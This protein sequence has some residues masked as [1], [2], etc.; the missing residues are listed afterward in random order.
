MWNN[1]ATLKK[2]CENCKWC[3][4]NARLHIYL[5][6]S[7][8]FLLI[9][10]CVRLFVL[11][12]FKT[13][14]AHDSR[15]CFSFRFPSRAHVFSWLVAWKFRVGLLNFSS[16]WFLVHFCCSFISIN[17]I[18]GMRCRQ[19]ASTAIRISHRARILIKNLAFI[20]HTWSFTRAEIWICPICIPIP[21]SS[22]IV[23]VDPFIYVFDAGDRQRAR[24]NEPRSKGSHFAI[25]DVTL[26]LNSGQTRNENVYCLHE[27]GHILNIWTNNEI[28]STDSTDWEMNGWGKNSRV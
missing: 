18:F 21:V 17:V 28:R 19:I 13:Y 2:T 6:I 16:F 23:D 11:R 20:F 25:S 14:W 22:M 8:F 24:R 10:L 3:A 15:F 26:S 12:R 9:C 4:Y 7:I 1:S 5:F 27:K